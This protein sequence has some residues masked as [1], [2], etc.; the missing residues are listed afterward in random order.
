MNENLNLVE[1]LK[2]CPKGTKLYSTVLGEVEFE[3]VTDSV[4][5]PIIVKL[6]EEQFGERIIE[7]FTSDG[8]LIATYKGECVLF[9]S[10]YQRDWSKF[11]PKKDWFVSPCEFKDG[12]ILS[13]QCKGFNNRSIYIYRY[14]KRFNTSYY[15]ALSGDDN[16]FR[17]DNTGKWS[18]N[19][20]NDTARFATEEE[21]QKLFQAIKDKGYKWNAETKTLEKLVEPR[22]NVG[23]WVVF[24]TSKSVYKVEKKENYEY[25]LRH[26]LGGSMCLPFSNE[27]LIIE[28]TIED[29]KDGDVI[30]YR[31]EISLY[32]HDI[33]NCTKQETTFGGFVYYCCYDGKRFITDSLY[34]LTKQDEIDIHPATKEQRDALM[35]AMNDAGYEWDADKKEL[36]EGESKIKT[37][38]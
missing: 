13:Y 30:C 7:T 20:Y 36:K 25:T 8:R 37:I 9:P 35:K 34:M 1:I 3:G 32:K 21:K 38:K 10:R 19:G 18:L 27:K 16:E 22:F 23:D 31:D 5:Y 11:N 33:K 26:I 24:I 15:V 2:D 4:N 14:H 12:D 29:A 17:I 6:K 28:W